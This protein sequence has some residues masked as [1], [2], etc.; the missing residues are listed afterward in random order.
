MRQM[1]LD[2][3]RIA[4]AAAIRLVY[5]NPVHEYPAEGKISPPCV[6]I[7]KP[8]IL[9]DTSALGLVSWDIN[10]Y[11]SRTDQGSVQKRLETDLQ[12]I[13]LKL[14]KGAGCNF[15]LRTVFPLEAEVSGYTLP[16]Y[17]IQATTTLPNC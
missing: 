11:D 14:A 7:G 15:V 5:T 17:T 1:T 4:M 13:M 12:A 10:L 9:F 6:V 3:Q 2:E 8:T 16:A